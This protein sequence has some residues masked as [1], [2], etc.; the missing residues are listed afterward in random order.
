MLFVLHV[1]EDSVHFCTVNHFILK[2]KNVYDKIFMKIYC[3]NFK[4]VF[5]KRR[6]SGFA[7]F[8]SGEQVNDLVQS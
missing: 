5:T 3:G 4:S 6:E 1:K 2:Q 7:V 8:L